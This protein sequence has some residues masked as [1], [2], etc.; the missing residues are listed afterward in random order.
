MANVIITEENFKRAHSEGSAEIKKTLENLAP[1]VFKPKLPHLGIYKVGG[2]ET[3]LFTGKGERGFYKGYV[4]D[5][6]TSSKSVG[7]YSETWHDHWIPIDS[8]REKE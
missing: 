8:I 1:E 5:P 3:V 2:R 7:Y 6:G 4:I